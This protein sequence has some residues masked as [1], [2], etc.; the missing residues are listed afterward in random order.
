MFCFFSTKGKP[1]APSPPT[2]EVVEATYISISWTPPSDDG[3]TPI[4]DYR[5]EHKEVSDTVWNGMKV[6]GSTH[7]TVKGLKESHSYS[8]QVAAEN[9]VGVGSFST[10]LEITTNGEILVIHLLID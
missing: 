2:F 9:K 1:H 10:P 4:I 3:G 6:E 5:V 7:T 8:F